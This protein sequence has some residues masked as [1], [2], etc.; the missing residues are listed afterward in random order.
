MRHALPVRRLLS[1]TALATLLLAAACGRRVAW[2][3][4]VEKEDGSK[5]HASGSTD[6]A[7]QDE[8]GAEPATPADDATKARVTTDEPAPP[9]PLLAQDGDFAVRALAAWLEQH[10]GAAGGRALLVLAAVD[11]ERA[12]VKFSAGPPPVTVGTA[13]LRRIAAGWEVE[14]L[15]DERSQTWIFPEAFVFDWHRRRAKLTMGDMRTLATAVE[16]YSIDNNVYPLAREV[17]D[18]ARLLEPTYVRGVPRADGWGRPLHF[19]STGM[20]YC[21]V[22]TGADGTPTRP[23][24]EYLDDGAMPP[25]AGGAHDPNGDI[26]FCTGSFVA[27][28]E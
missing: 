8:R 24:A 11:S 18:V 14:Q 15:F 27:W 22:S 16:S 13:R 12:V 4:E 20:T 26:V 19:R 25:S 28:W 2:Q 17:A 1:L 9:D 6:E 5:K 7:G 10:L 3:V 21:I 23:L